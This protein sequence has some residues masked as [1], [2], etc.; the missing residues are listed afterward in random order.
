MKSNSYT[1]MKNKLLYAEDIP[2]EESC[3][4]A[5]KVMSDKLVGIE[6]LHEDFEILYEDH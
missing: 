2:Y 3:I 5:N 6:I 4:F 1:I